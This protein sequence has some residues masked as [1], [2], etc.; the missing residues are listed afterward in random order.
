MAMFITNERPDRETAEKADFQAEEMPD[1]S[2]EIEY[3]PEDYT[4]VKT[5]SFGNEA[6]DEFKLVR[7]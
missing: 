1:G 6:R 4:L 3:N 2:I 5:V 7:K